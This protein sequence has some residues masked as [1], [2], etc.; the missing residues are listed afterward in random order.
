MRRLRFLL[1]AIISALATALA[2]VGAGVGLAGS[3][4][5]AAPV[6]PTLTDIRAAHHSGFDRLVFEFSGPLPEHTSVRWVDKVIADGSGQKVRVAGNALLSVRMFNANGHTDT[7]PSTYGPAR[8]AFALPNIATV[9]NSGDFEATLSFGVGLMKR[10]SIL[11]TQRL[12]SP[13]RYVV[14][15]RTNFER[16]TAAVYFLDEDAFNGGT[17]PFV[18]PVLRSVPISGV[19]RGALHRLYA[20]P[21]QAEQADS[22]RLVRS[23]S[24]GFADFAI[25]STKVARLRLTGGC[26]SGGSTF[27]VANEIR[28]TLRQFASI[29]WIK[30]YSP[31][32][33]T[34]QP[35]GPSDSIP[36]CLEP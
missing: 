28:P 1:V 29:K 34:Q 12:T 7:E 5:G 2:G 36:A 16:R 17:P 30:I 15:V 35:S 21:T 23:Q 10:T 11:R 18:Q 22:L 24:S 13:S 26:S 8:R 25:S 19:A 14:D 20:G 9:V 27:T 6:I 4:A 32:G 33:H 31:T 3:A